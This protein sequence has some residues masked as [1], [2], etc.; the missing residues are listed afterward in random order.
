MSDPRTQFRI[1]ITADSPQAGK[2]TATYFFQKYFEDTLGTEVSVIETSDLVL[3]KYDAEYGTSVLQNISEKHAHRR[4]IGLFAQRLNQ[5]Y[6]DFFVDATRGLPRPLLISGMRDVHSLDRFKSEGD[7]VIRI[8]T[9]EQTRRR[10]LTEE[11]YAAF[12]VSP[13]EH[14]LDDLPESFYHAVIGNNGSEEEFVGSLWRVATLVLANPIPE[15][16]WHTHRFP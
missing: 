12:L 7:W 13:R 3:A 14:E 11:Q 5:E 16:G 1:V 8:T 15:S 9:T 4:E 6:P 10:R 2:S